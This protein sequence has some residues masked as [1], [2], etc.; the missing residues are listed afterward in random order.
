MRDEDQQWELM[1]DQ[2][3]KR[4]DPAGLGF[5]TTEAL[6]EPDQLMGQQRAHEAIDFAL[7]LDGQGYNL[8]VAG[9]PGSG[10]ST[11]ALNAVRQA[12]AERKAGQDWC[13]VYHFDRP[14]EPIAIALPAGGGQ[15][16]ARDIDQ[17]VSASRRALRRAFGDDAYRQQRS[18]QLSDISARQTQM[19]EELQQEARQHGFLLQAAPNGLALI[20]V[21]PAAPR[22]AI[23]GIHAQAQE[24]DVQPMSEDEFAALPPEEQQRLR[25]E[26]DRLEEMI[27]GVMSS[28]HELEEE[29]LERVRTL[30]L[31]IAHQA[32]DPIAQALAQRYAD[33]AKI[34]D[35]ARHLTNDMCAHADV[36]RSLPDSRSDN[37]TA[38]SEDSKSTGPEA[39]ADEPPNDESLLQDDLRERPD[40]GWLLR[41]YRVNVLV[42]RQASDHAPI[43]QEINPDYFNLVGR[44]EFGV[45]NGLPYTDHLL[46][47][48]G[49]L[50][51]ANGGYLVVQA[52]DLLSRPHA[53]EALKRVLRFGV[54]GL[55]SSD[56]V[57]GAPASAS[58][59]PEAIPATIKVVL[60]GDPETYAAL[61]SLDPDFH[62][63]FKVRADFAAA[64]PRTGET[65][66]F[67]AQFAGNLART[68]NRPPLAAEA[69]AALIEEGSRWAEDQDRL[70][71][72]LSAI[73][74]LTLEASHIA[75]KE[76]A[77]TISRAHVL[78]AVV[79]RERRSSLVSDE[80]DRMIEQRTILIDTTGEVVGQIN[81]LTVLQVGDFAFGKPARITARTS[82]GL[83]GIVNLERE[84][85]MSGPAHSKGILILSGYLAGRYAQNAPLSMS[86]SICFEQI[87]GGIEGDSASSAELYALLSSLSGLPIRQSLAVTGSVNQLGEVQ[88]VGGVTQ[89]VEGFFQVCRERGLTG[90]QGVIIPQANVRNLML[91][92]EVVEAI[93]AGQFHLYAVRTIDE[94]IELLTGT[95]AGAPDEQGSYPEQSVNG[96]VARTLRMFTDSVRGI[97]APPSTAGVK[98]S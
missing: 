31:S 87:Y 34:A 46:I 65:E 37:S 22:L 67:Y 52:R 93:Q 38:P 17:F 27:Q 89:K 73:E 5:Q 86:G 53:W 40:Q 91:R 55:E 88:A 10:R 25:A 63:L 50:H 14:N 83:A 7:A 21:K 8:F 56:L 76:Q 71:T 43:E 54:I 74:D 94:G 98:S 16:F 45:L 51:R 75:A 69:V 78:Q 6:P 30:D 60:I 3:R 82:P 4:A 18:A 35:F 15:A 42:A 92:D 81:G 84:T 77:Q 90:D 48:A 58:L 96:R 2:V 12:A 44:I 97:A 59:R 57:P 72:D 19:I 61:L 20:P 26:H 47:K 23:P 64:M 1:P 49:S 41:R 62:T 28:M 36:L 32:I 79:A 66:R 29:A 70:S 95:P 24:A 9:Q 80:I 33:S 68:C 85:M 11:T 13:Y 39:Q